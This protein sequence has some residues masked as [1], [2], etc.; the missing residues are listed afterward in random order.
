MITLLGSLLGFGSS[1]LP[2]VLNFFKAGQEHKQKMES[3]KL[4]M[5]LMSKRSELQLNMLDKQAD[6]KETEGLYKH[7]S[8]DAGGFVNALRGSVRPVITY[9]FFGLFVAVQVV[10]M[11]KVMDEGGD[12]A[13]AVTLMWTPE[14][15]GLFAAI[16]S[17]WFGNRAVSKY[18]GAKK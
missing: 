11:V 12:W 6:I 17:F 13:S 8:I 5:E 3:M 7:D 15:S 16:M 10:I 9:A 1:F 18:L 2:E 4:E 14:T